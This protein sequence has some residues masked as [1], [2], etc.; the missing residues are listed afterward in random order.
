MPVLAGRCLVQHEA[1]QSPRGSGTTNGRFPDCDE[2]TVAWEPGRQVAAILDRHVAVPTGA[3]GFL[4][5]IGNTHRPTVNTVAVA[6]MTTT[7]SLASPTRRDA[8]LT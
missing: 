5:R 1:R 2:R 7:L 4:I 6:G 3:G 8:A